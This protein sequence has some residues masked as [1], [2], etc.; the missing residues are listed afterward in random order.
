VYRDKRQV[1]PTRADLVARQPAAGASAA[2]LDLRPIGALDRDLVGAWVAV[3]GRVADINRIQQGAIL[4]LEDGDSQIS[5]AAF[6][7]WAGVPFSETLEAGDW[8]IVQGEV[9]EY[10]R[11]LEIVP[12]LPMDLALAPSD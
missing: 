7:P 10:R 6:E 12:E 3:R 5:V 8:L 4:E 11:K 9:A 2:L 1:L